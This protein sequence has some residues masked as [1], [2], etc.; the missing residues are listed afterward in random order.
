MNVEKVRSDEGKKSVILGG[1]EMI[2]CDGLPEGVDG[3][4]FNLHDPCIHAVIERN[5]RE[6]KEISA[7]VLADE[8]EFFS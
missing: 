8:F 2:S 4:I 6:L 7:Q 3:V 1:I 5:R